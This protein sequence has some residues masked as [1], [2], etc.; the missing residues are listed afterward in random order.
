MQATQSVRVPVMSRVFCNFDL[1]LRFGS[2][3]CPLRRA[4]NVKHPGT[5]TTNRLPNHHP[6]ASVCRSPVRAGIFREI[7]RMEITAEQATRKWRNNSASKKQS[8]MPNARPRQSAYIFAR[9]SQKLTIASSK[10]RLTEPL[11]RC[12]SR[13]VRARNLPPSPFSPHTRA[14]P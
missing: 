14:V 3:A 2:G 5:P 11:L 12:L 6:K 1:A 8:S 10:T 7:P 9:E 4:R 13:L